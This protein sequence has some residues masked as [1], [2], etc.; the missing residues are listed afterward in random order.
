MHCAAHG[1]GESREAFTYLGTHWAENGYITVFLTHPGSDRK[2]IEEQGLRGMGGVKDFHLRPE[3]VRFVLDKLLSNDAGS[4]LL[5]GRLAAEQIAVAGQCAGASTALAM[6]G[7]RANLPE[8]QDATF[9]DPR[10]KCAIALSPQ[11]GGGRSSPLHADSWARIE[12]PTLMV[13]G[14]PASIPAGSPAAMRANSIRATRNP[15]RPSLTA[16][17]NAAAVS[18]GTVPL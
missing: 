8:K 3:D 4:K 16:A 7:L 1:G 15:T 18:C 5:Q 10:F 12:V 11:P 14:T 17:S 9:I 6:V 2:A 13:T